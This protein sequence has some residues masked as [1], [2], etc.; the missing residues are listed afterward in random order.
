VLPL[1]RGE[2]AAIRATLAPGKTR[3]RP[4]HD[5]ADDDGAVIDRFC[6]HSPK[7][8]TAEGYGLVKCAE[9]WRRIRVNL[10]KRPFGNC[11]LQGCLRR[12]ISNP[13]DN[14]EAGV[15]CSYAT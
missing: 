3:R 12:T 8:T 6:L 10:A 15:G 7:A 11:E 14:L 9:S 13:A 4:L 2:N 1:T 5:R